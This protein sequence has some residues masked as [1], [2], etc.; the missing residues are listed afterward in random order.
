MLILRGIRHQYSCNVLGNAIVL[1]AVVLERNRHRD[2]WK[3]DDRTLDYS[4]TM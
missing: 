2:L 1:P 3:W 4:S